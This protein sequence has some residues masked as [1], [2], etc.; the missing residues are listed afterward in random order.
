MNPSS[1]E[2]LAGA[3][4]PGERVFLPGSGG[5]SPG[6]T[7]ALISDPAHTRGLE[8]VTSFLPGVNPLAIE[9]MSEDARVLALFMQPAFQSAARLGRVEQLPVSY[10]GFARDLRHSWTFDTTVAHV[11]PPNADGLCSLGVAAE[12]TLLAAARSR[13]VV[14]VLNAQMPALARSPSIPIAA[15]ALFAIENAPLPIYDPGPPDAASLKIGET[16]A[17]LIPDGGIVQLGIGKTSTATAAT[18]RGH[19]RLRFWSGMISDGFLDLARAGALDEGAIHL[20]CAALGSAG[21]YT[22]LAGRDDIRVA[23]CDVTHDAATLA[24]LS[25][26]FAVNSALEVDLFGQCNLEQ[27]AGAM[28]SGA[29]GAPDFARAA[30]RGQGLSTIA[31]PATAS[32]G[33]RSR[34]VPRLEGGL[35]S[36]ARHEVDVVVTEFGAADLRGLSVEARAR[37][38]IDIAEPSFREGLARAWRDATSSPEGVRS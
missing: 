37:A 3:F 34:I 25:S 8:I 10:A 38:L 28:V 22:E 24:G 9:R 15:F 13:R 14:G 23:G 33:A 21:F 6:F 5:E 1:L 26:L 35:V 30:A 12:F 7:E 36:L 4:S 2:A 32:R 18:L 20:C 31:L 17:A 19:R 29:G 16:I 11:S 27:A